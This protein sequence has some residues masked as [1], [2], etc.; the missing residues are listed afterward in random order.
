LTRGDEDSEV[1]VRFLSEGRSREDA[2]AALCRWAR[3]VG[4]R[5]VWLPDRVVTLDPEPEVSRRAEV[6]C[7]ICGSRW[8][9]S[10]PEFWQMVRGM[11]TFPK[12]CVICGW[13]LPQWE[14]A[15]EKP[16]VEGRDRTR[17]AT[18]TDPA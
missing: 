11:G 7:R 17:A 15:S 16:G 8:H 1:I 13:E 14:I 5:R 9:D 12:W 4:Y 2:D 18:R 3:R 6:R 10:T